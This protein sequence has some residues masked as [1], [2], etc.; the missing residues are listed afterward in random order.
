MPRSMAPPPSGEFHIQLS[1]PF[2]GMYLKT[3]LIY[4]NPNTP[5]RLTVHATLSSPPN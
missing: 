1:K 4:P 5:T 3:R 2:S